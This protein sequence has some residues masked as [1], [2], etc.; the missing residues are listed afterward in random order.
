MANQSNIIGKIEITI[1][2]NLP[3][4]ILSRINSAI[5][6]LHKYHIDVVLQ[7][8]NLKDSFKLIIK[9]LEIGDITDKQMKEVFKIMFS[10]V[11]DDSSFSKLI[12]NEKEFRLPADIEEC[13]DWFIIE[14]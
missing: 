9:I 2:K 1:D 4:E 3:R 7:D 13:L 10:G 12:D 11:K 6:Y 5:S 14:K 8:S